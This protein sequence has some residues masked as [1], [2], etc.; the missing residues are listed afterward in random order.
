MICSKEKSHHYHHINTGIN[1]FVHFLPQQPDRGSKAP[2]SE[3]EGDAEKLDY[4]SQSAQ[5][6]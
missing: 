6:A 3:T 1:S 5:P 4:P 2:N